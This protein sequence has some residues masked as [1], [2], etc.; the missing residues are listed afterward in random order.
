MDDRQFG[1]PIK[2]IHLR[3]IDIFC[4]SIP[5]LNLSYTFP[6]IADVDSTSSDISNFSIWRNGLGQDVYIV[7]CALLG[8]G[9]NDS[10]NYISTLA[11][12]SSNNNDIQN[13]LIK[14]KFI[15]FITNFSHK[16]LSGNFTASLVFSDSNTE[17]IPEFG[18]EDKPK[19]FI[20]LPRLKD[21]LDGMKN[22][23]LH[24]I[25]SQDD[26]ANLFK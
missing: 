4:D 24:E 10:L 19:K 11:L 18:E 8:F 1:V 3:K 16:D 21:T 15:P 6:N 2:Y 9:I 13:P 12:D 23:Y 25:P 17:S 26:I 14:V 5:D 7:R 20:S 22:I